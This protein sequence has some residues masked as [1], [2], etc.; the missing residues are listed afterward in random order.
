MRGIEIEYS[1]EQDIYELRVP[2]GSGVFVGFE[3]SLEAGIRTMINKCYN[4]LHVSEVSEDVRFNRL[5]EKDLELASQLLR[6]FP[7][8]TLMYSPSM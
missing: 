3:C 5:T 6:R 8:L 4:Q 7:H 2:S 1:A